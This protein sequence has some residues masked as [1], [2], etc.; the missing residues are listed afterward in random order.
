MTEIMAFGCTYIG[1][2]EDDHGVFTHSSGRV[3]AGKVVRGSAS[4][5]V[6]TG[7]SGDTAFVECDANGEW[8]G[9]LLGCTADGHTA[10]QRWKH[11]SRYVYA[12]LNADGTCIY[13]GRFCRADYAPFKA[14]QA[15]VLPI[16]ARPHSRPHAAF[17]PPPPP[18]RSTHRPC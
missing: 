6:L 4:V 12:I 18:N 15:K 2:A 16:K 17:Q 9:R 8:H 1:T 10:Y 5:G 11:G 3:Y 14:L 13:N 7:T